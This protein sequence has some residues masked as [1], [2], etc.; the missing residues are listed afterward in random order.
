MVF[1]IMFHNVEVLPSLNPYTKTQEE[2]DRYIDDLERFFQYCNGN[3]IQGI[4]LSETINIYAKAGAKP[5][6]TF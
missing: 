5:V 1:N 3:N 4:G 6:M 2:C